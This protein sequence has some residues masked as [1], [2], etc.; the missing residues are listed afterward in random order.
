M[1]E[2]AE[3]IEENEQKSKLP[4]ILGFAATLILGVGI[5]FGGSMFTENDPQPSNNSGSDES[6][7]SAS[8]SDNPP[9]E[10]EFR[11]GRGIYPLGLFTVNLRGIGGGKVL[12]MEIDLE[13]KASKLDTLEDKK[14]GL[15]DRVI[16]LVSD[17]HYQDVEGLDGKQRLQD[18]LLA[19]MNKYMGKK[20]RIERVYF[21]Q[22][23]VQ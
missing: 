3:E 17:Y 9:E 21:S 15:R 19:T 22:F 23:V 13:L 16:K 18:D 7:S 1:P 4:T 5:G 2:G 8:S 12:R 20:A 14:A 6:S 11:D 10:G